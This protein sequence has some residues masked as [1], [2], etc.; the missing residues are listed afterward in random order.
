MRS[1]R[2]EVTLCLL[3]AAAPAAAESRVGGVLSG[4]TTWTQ[5]ES[6]YLVGENVEVPRGA[7]LRIEPGV[8]VRFERYSLVVR[9]ELVARGTAEAP[10]VMTSAQETPAPGDWLFVEFRQESTAASFDAAG[11]YGAGSVLEH[12]RIEYGA[13]V[14]LVGGSP[15]LYRCELLHNYSQEGGGVFIGGGSSVIRDCRIAYNRADRHG[16]GVRH[17]AGSPRLIGNRIEYNSARMNGGGVASNYTP[18]YLSGNTVAHNAAA[19]GGGVAT[20]ITSSSGSSLMGSAR[21]DPVLQDNLIAHNTARY[22]GAGL[23]VRGAPKLVGNRVLFNWVS[24]AKRPDRDHRRARVDSTD[25]RK[26]TGGGLHLEGTFGSRAE[27]TGNVL[28]GNAGAR[29]GAALFTEQASLVFRDN[30]VARNEATSFGG[31]LSLVCRPPS[32]ARHLRGHGTTLEVE[33]SHFEGNLAGDIEV[34][35]T[36]GQSVTIRRC[37]FAMGDEPALINH[38]RVR[39]DAREAW[40]GAAGVDPAERVY[41][42]GDDGSLGRVLH[43]RRDEPYGVSD[44]VRQAGEAAALRATAPEEFRAAFGVFQTQG[45]PPAV[46]A[47]WKPVEADWVAGYKLHLTEVTKTYRERLPAVTDEGVSPVDVGKATNRRVGGLKRGATYELT[48]WA[49]DAEGREGM[50]AVPVLVTAPK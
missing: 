29:W 31:G 39:I 15:Y 30:Y 1:R 8:V 49:Y 26:T 11:E 9:G 35:G 20:G 22:A 23:H 28:V 33:G 44:A 19:N 48:V 36:G 5:A 25:R 27:L 7:S 42:G 3:L 38:S 14:N 34:T 4:A 17:A 37:D 43:Q 10:I 45:R 2:A 32:K 24:E 40:W 47:T 12:V 16:G 50:A 21:S 6:P 13:G 46:T 41:D 18:S